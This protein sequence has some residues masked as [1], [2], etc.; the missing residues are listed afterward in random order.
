MGPRRG[1]RVDCILAIMR[2][3]AKLDKRTIRREEFEVLGS[4]MPGVERRHEKNGG[5]WGAAERGA[6][7]IKN[8]RFPRH[9][10]T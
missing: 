2:H 9:Q 8:V 5:S 10:I 7:C 6:S 4:I 3:E 1:R